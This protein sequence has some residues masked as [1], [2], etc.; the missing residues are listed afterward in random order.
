MTAA[1]QTAARLRSQLFALTN[2]FKSLQMSALAAGQ[3]ELS[4]QIDLTAC[5]LARVYEDLPDLF[6]DAFRDPKDQEFSVKL[7]D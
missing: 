3:C 7:A 5:R 1:N 6:V 4:G 2:E